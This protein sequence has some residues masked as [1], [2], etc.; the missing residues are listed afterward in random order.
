MTKG[1]GKGDYGRFCGESLLVFLG[2]GY[3]FIAKLTNKE[4]EYGK[5][6]DIRA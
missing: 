5:S 6:T 1:S 4:Y 3:N 2:P